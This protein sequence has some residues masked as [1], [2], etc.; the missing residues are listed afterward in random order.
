MADTPDYQ[1]QYEAHRTRR[2][3]IAALQAEAVVQQPSD[4]EYHNP[5]A[6]RLFAAKKQQTLKLLRDADADSAHEME[7]IDRA[8]AQATPKATTEA[9]QSAIDKRNADM[10]AKAAKQQEDID[11][12]K[13]QKELAQSKEAQQKQAGAES[14]ITLGAGSRTLPDLLKSGAGI[15]RDPDTGNYV[16]TVPNTKGTLT[17]IQKNA[18]TQLQ[19]AFA[20][21]YGTT[22]DQVFGPGAPVP[23]FDAKGNSIA[24][25]GGNPFV[26]SKSE[27]QGLAGLYAKSQPPEST[28]LSVPASALNKAYTGIA[29]AYGG[30]L[31]GNPVSQIEAVDAYQGDPTNALGE[32]RA[33]AQID[34]MGRPVSFGIRPGSLLSPAEGPVLPAPSELTQTMAQPPATSTPEGTAAVAAAKLDAEQQ[35]TGV[36]ANRLRELLIA[37][38][39]DPN[40]PVF[41]EARSQEQKDIAS[42]ALPGQVADYAGIAERYATPQ[43]LAYNIPMKAGGLIQRGA[44]SLADSLSAQAALE[45]QA[46]QAR[47]LE[48][49][50][51]LDLS[52]LAPG[53]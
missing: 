26:G 38:G 18:Q 2:N 14:A 37:T 34:Q 25:P 33:Q 35:Q 3:D 41:K 7:K 17:P 10:A 53:S 29:P 13:Q 21:Q 27:F 48:P 52:T 28:D 43:G 11:A 8:R 6:R 9:Q 42:R 30:S 22:P 36:P 23:R 20:N 46:R 51:D 31:P 5:N 1:A 24:E 50:N 32:G 15:R 47:G 45:E 16:F 4:F 39:G 19:K 44:G 12:Q 40:S 49:S